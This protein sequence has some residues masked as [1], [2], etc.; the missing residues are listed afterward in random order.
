LYQDCGF[1]ERQL[2]DVLEG[3]GDLAMRPELN[4]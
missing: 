3:D 4:Q 1:A 2:E